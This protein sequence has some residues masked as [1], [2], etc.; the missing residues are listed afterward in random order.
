MGRL[1]LIG[2]IE[3]AGEDV[4]LAWHM[5]ANIY[6][7]RPALKSVAKAAIVAVREGEPER[8]IELPTGYSFGRPENPDA[9][10]A[11][12]PAGHVIHELRLDAFLEDGDEL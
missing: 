1:S 7:P 8:L 9:W 4:A 11:K 5:D 12:V 6:P 3:M 2:M 10:K